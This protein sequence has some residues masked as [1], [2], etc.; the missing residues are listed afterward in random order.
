MRAAIREIAIFA[1]YLLL[2]VV[3]TWPLAIRLTTAVAGLGDPLLNTWI[4]DWDCYA[5]THSPFHLFQAPIFYPAKYPLAYSENLVGIALVCLPFYLA[6]LAS[7]TI[8]NIAVLLGFAFSAYGGFVLARVVTRRTAGS[9]IAGILFGFVPYR[10]DHL[11]H[12]QIIW[13]GWLALLLAALLVYRRSP[14]WRNAALAGAAFVMNGLTNIHYLL[15]GSVAF[16]LTLL[17]IALTESRDARFWSRLFAALVLGALVL[18]PFLLPYRIVSRQYG[19]KR[20]EGESLLG[21][22]VPT[23]WLI[24]PSQS[25]LY[26]RVTDEALRHGER[27]LFP[28]LLPIALLGAAL[29]LTPRRQ[30]QN[31]ASPPRRVPLLWLDIAIVVFALL[32][33]VGA[34]TDGIVIT[35]RGHLLLDFG[36]S[37]IPATLLVACVLARLAIRFPRGW[38][39]GNLRTVLARS[40]FPLELW[41]AALWIVVGVLGSFGLNAFFHGFLFHKIVAFRSIR[42]PARWAM[43]TYAGLTVWSAAGFAAMQPRRWRIALLFALALLDVWPSIRWEHA[44]VEP[45]AADRWL[46][47]SK[48]AP[49]IELPVHRLDVIFIYLLGATAHHVPIFNGISGFEPPL[50]RALR[51]HPL[52]DKLLDLLERNGCRFILVHPDWFGW[53][54]IGALQWLRRNVGQ[55]RLAFVRRFDGG[56]NGDWL[57]ALPTVAVDW[58]RFRAPAVPDRAGFTP[59]QE[60]LRLFNGQPTYNDSTFGQLEQP[61]RG[62]DVAGAMTVS[63]WAL[64][65]YGIRSINVRIDSGRV[66]LPA[67]LMPRPGV[68]EHFPWYPQTPR[69]MFALTLPRRPWSVP[70]DTDVQIEIIDGRGHVT[71]LPDLPLTWR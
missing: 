5:L 42:A 61:K 3:L 28:G 41:A 49:L 53:E 66:R 38:G 4:L 6:G 54:A 34:V 32:T 22:A 14:T 52:D 1:C 56:I 17:L 23:D 39:D 46:A 70:R 11:P 35:W 15:F 2:A 45:R 44:L 18:L 64:S 33:Y 50:H 59:E 68:S 71:L 24:A 67:E 48:A 31:Q 55:G 29:L 25:A 57:F 10:F 58:E 51:E 27:K 21:S 40:R 26:G 63:G 8:Y 20:G 60:L 9:L 19:M 7:L 47:E 62:P 37:F 36:T 69:P 13:G 65:P 12:V 43:V 30:E 16:A